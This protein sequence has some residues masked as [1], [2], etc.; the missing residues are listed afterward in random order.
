MLAFLLAAGSALAQQQ[1][2]PLNKVL[3]KLADEQNIFFAYDELLLRKIKVVPPAVGT[4]TEVWLETVLRKQELRYRQINDTYVIYPEARVAAPEQIISLHGSV[5]DAESGEP[6]P[7]AT[8]RILGTDRYVVA[9]EQGD[10]SLL[11]IPASGANIEITYLGYQPHVRQ[12]AAPDAMD[13][14]RLALNA[15]AEQLNTVV[16][17]A[18]SPAVLDV[19]SDASQFSLNARQI[20]SLSVLGEPDLFRQVQL[21]PG[22]SASS[23]NSAGLIIRGGNP[24]QSLVLFDDFTIYHIDHFYGIYSAFNAGTIQDVQL[25]KG[26]FGA[27][28]GGR[29]NGVLDIIGKQGNREKVSG[30]VL[31]NLININGV[32]E[33]PVGD[34]LTLMLAG[35]RAYTDVIESR[36]FRRLFNSVEDQLPENSVTKIFDQPPSFYFY[37]LNSKLTWRPTEQDVASISFYSGRDN[38]Q[39][40]SNLLQQDSASNIP[41]DYEFA[42]DEKWG[43]DGISLRWKRRWTNQHHSSFSLAHS[44][45]F[46]TGV[47]GIEGFALLSESESESLGRF[48]S[49]KDNQLQE[50]KVKLEHHWLFSPQQSLTL[51][52]FSTRNQI[53]FLLREGGETVEAI[54]STGFRAGVFGSWEYRLPRADLRIGLRSTADRLSAKAFAEPRIN[55]GYDLSERWRFS[56]G[57]GRYYQFVNYVLVQDLFEGNTQIWLTPDDQEIPILRSTNITAGLRY[58]HNDWLVNL[59]AYYRSFDGLLEYQQSEIE[60]FTE[61]GFNI[62]NDFVTGDGISQGIE[63]LVQ[64]R[65]GN[66]EAWASY[67]LSQTVNQFD[68]LNNGLRYYA[69]FDQRH[70]AKATA[71]WQK[72]PWNL[73][74]S[75]IYG[76]GRPYTEPLNTISVTLSTG[77]VINLPFIPLI[78][79]SRL[80]AYHRFDLN[81]SYSFKTGND[82]KFTVGTSLFNLY[83]RRNIRSR[84]FVLLDETVVQRDVEMLGFT[85]TLSLSYEF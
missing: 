75:F 11:Q 27:R 18:Q 24:E 70:E 68:E 37:D 46:R 2:E 39:A 52:F 66:F 19:G 74:G 53:N 32:L 54:D 73:N 6:L 33:V 40:G 56:I 35:R 13:G 60:L 12:V 55:F 72:G 61:D 8:I 78:N 20:N 29:I 77:Q 22:V 36:L 49:R 25:Y 34:K 31:V 5:Q 85:P 63:L 58:K 3:R 17:Q 42:E 69:D 44:D 43:N 1:Q 7:Y 4:S 80:P 62:D 51:G 41:I 15:E 67:T 65:L 9:N 64:R 45:F 76:S 14:L 10:F 79:N 38:L 47:L 59:E 82:S 23:E 81:A 26:G 57:A 16:V 48:E 30:R 71:I 50:T 28:Y 84:S 83:N 21:M